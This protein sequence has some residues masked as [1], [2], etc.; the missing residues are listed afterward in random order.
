MRVKGSERAPFLRLADLSQESSEYASCSLACQSCQA[1]C[2]AVQR[3][4]AS[5]TDMHTTAQWMIKI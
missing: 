1:E 3:A 5:C 4:R 2:E